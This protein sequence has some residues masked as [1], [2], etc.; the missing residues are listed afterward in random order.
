MLS[1]RITCELAVVAVLCVLMIFLFP[2]MQGSYSMVHGPVTALMA[3]RA[4][5]RLRTAIV[6]GALNCLGNYLI[7][8]LVVLSWMSFSNT[9][10]QS[11]GLPEYNIVLRC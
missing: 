3:A 8:P 5:A 1:G 7:S 9:E 4:A 10:F 2:S 11:V 6:Q